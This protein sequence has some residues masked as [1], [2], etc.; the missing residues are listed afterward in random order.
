MNF[1]TSYEIYELL[2]FDKLDINELK[3]II[4]IKV[5]SKSNLDLKEWV[6]PNSFGELN[7]S[8]FFIFCFQTN[9]HYPGVD[10]DKITIARQDVN[11]IV[12]NGKYLAIGTGKKYASDSC[13]RMKSINFLQ[14]EIF[15]KFQHKKL[16]L[17]DSDFKWI[18]ENFGTIPGIRIVPLSA[19]DVDS[20]E[21]AAL[22]V[23]GSS[24][25]KKY[26]SNPIKKI[27]I[28]IE[29]LSTKVTFSENITTINK[30]TFTI[31]EDISV[32]EFLLD[33]IFSQTI[34]KRRSAQLHLSYIDNNKLVAKGGDKDR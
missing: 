4:S 15:G 22:N 2:F 32:L 8:I 30:K 20:V 34:V 29:D 10:E 12:I 1:L 11:I 26:I 23:K 16:E 24:F 21:A 33:H 25:C 14:N 27:K 18:Y 17:N 7:N 31:K 19:D 5:F 9:Y 13:I 28:Y 3:K 6:K